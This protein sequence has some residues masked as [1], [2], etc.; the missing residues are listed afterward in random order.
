MICGPKNSQVHLIR[1]EPSPVGLRLAG[2]G[3]RD[4]WLP[5]VLVP[6]TWTTGMELGQGLFQ[7]QKNGALT[8]KNGG[9]TSKKW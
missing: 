9:S 5:L 7:W 2:L 1:A 8:M 3:A 6:G 4:L